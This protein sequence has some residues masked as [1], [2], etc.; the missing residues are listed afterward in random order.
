MDDQEAGRPTEE[1]EA[2]GGGERSAGPRLRDF[3]TAAGVLTCLPWSRPDPKSAAYGRSTPFFPLVGLC[4]GAALV[5]L[6]RLLA[7]A[8][9]RWIGAALVVGLWDVVGTPFRRHLSPRNDGVGERASLA[10]AAPEAE[11]LRLSRMKPTKGAAS[12]GNQ[13]LQWAWRDSAGEFYSPAMRRGRLF[14]MIICT[15]AKVLALAV[16]AST[17]PAALLFAPMLARWGLVVLM[18]G[19]RD[20]AAPA[21]KFNTAIAFREFALASV[22]SFVAL[23]AVAEAFGIF[24]AACVAALTLAIRLLAHRWWGGVSWPLLQLTAQLIETTVLVLFALP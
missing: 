1:A 9:P 2:S 21:Q 7:P 6:Q 3:F 22:F 13:P 12:G 20:A 5:G 19:A 4:M 23:F 17:R 15:V 18:V 24:I 10:V 11:S 16:P 8:L 14:A